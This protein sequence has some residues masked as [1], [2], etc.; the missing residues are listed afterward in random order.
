MKENNVYKSDFVLLY[1]G[2]PYFKI[3][4]F[5]MYDVHLRFKFLVWTEIDNNK[6]KSLIACL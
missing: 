1:L 5:T 3:S 4:W 2:I 6:E